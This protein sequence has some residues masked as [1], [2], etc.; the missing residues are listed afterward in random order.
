MAMGFNPP[1]AEN[2][3]PNLRKSDPTTNLSTLM[4]RPAYLIRITSSHANLQDR[5]PL[6][7]PIHKTHILPSL[8]GPRRPPFICLQKIV[9]G[10]VELKNK[11]CGILSRLSSQ[12]PTNPHNPKS[13][14]A[15]SKTI[16]C[17]PIGVLRRPWMTAKRE[18]EPENI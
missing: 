9:R 6:Q 17:T 10:F 13:V 15:A 3:S 7:C 16:P 18:E 12:N 5:I 4:T 14:E 2:V 11:V 1:T 8:L